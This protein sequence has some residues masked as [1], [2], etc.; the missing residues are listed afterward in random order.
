MST[1]AVDTQNPCAAQT[2]QTVTLPPIPE[3]F[4]PNFLDIL[5]PAAEDV[6]MREGEATKVASNTMMD[7]LRSTAH[8]KFTAN[9]APAFSSTLVSTL[10]AY[11][12]LRTGI[13]GEKVDRH[14]D[15]AWAEDPDLTLRVI[16]ST[17]SIHDG[18]G[19]KEL[20]YR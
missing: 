20:F 10:D 5:I 6:P 12:G 7:A 1:M 14:L 19:E 18:K 15:N 11:V 9:C 4:D 16:W 3:L 2:S 13:T 8:H 17:R